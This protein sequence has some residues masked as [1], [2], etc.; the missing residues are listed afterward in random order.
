MFQPTEKQK[1]LLEKKLNLIWKE[2]YLPEFQ[3]FEDFQQ[4]LEKL[5]TKIKKRFNKTQNTNLQKNRS[6]EKLLNYCLNLIDK[7]GMYTEN[8]LRE[9]MNSKTKTKENIEE[10]VGKLKKQWLIDDEKYAKMMI[11][12]QLRKGKWYYQIMKKLKEKW[13]TW[14][15][16]PNEEEEKESLQEILDKFIKHKDFKDLSYNKK[17]QKLLSRLQ[18]KWYRSPIIMETIKEYEQNEKISPVEYKPEDFQKKEKNIEKDSKKVIKK[19]K[20]NDLSNYK[21]KS[22]FFQ[23]MLYR[24]YNYDEINEYLNSKKE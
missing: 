11:E 17:R 14:N 19:F 10:I 12:Q 22:K 24:W 23:K 9:K 8:K 1:Q 18:R 13:Y 2:Y 4:Y 16:K 5:D 6:K 7:F 15:Q 20:F 21:Q 3:N